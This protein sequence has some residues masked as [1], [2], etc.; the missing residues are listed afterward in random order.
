M[1]R[2]FSR[3]GAASG[4]LFVLAVMVGSVLNAVGSSA[5]EEGPVSVATYQRQLTT[6]NRIGWS[7]VVLGFVALVVFLGY[8]TRW[9]RRFEAHDGWL[10]TAVGFAGLLYLALGLGEL[11]T[12][13][14]GRNPGDELTT[15]IASTL[16]DL[17][18]A[19]FAVSGL[20]FGVFVLLAG[21]HCL[22][23]RSFPRW[24]GVMGVCLGVLT[25]AAGGVG[26]VSMGG[27]LPAPYV[28]SL[29]W[30]L[31]LSARLTI[32]AGKP[33]IASAPGTP[34]RPTAEDDVRKRGG[35]RADGARRTSA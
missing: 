22:A 30:T 12:V 28:A 34:D 25:T 35:M 26:V 16:L 2:M 7:L 10:S 13:M 33:T 19:A 31:C 5:G 24:L 6:T 29:A 27:Y 3:L 23:Y 21:A 14:A 32:A 20:M 9:L 17:D 1:N 18:E 15:E 8:F 4:A 11:V